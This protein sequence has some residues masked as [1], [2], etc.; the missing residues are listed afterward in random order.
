M[1]D[2]GFKH[3]RALRVRGEDRSSFATPVN[4]RHILRVYWSRELIER[5][6]KRTKL[7]PQH[8]SWKGQQSAPVLDLGIMRHEDSEL[9]PND[10]VI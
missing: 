8:T 7:I 4:R 1:L 2:R 3:K 10:W 9:I 6:G 5:Y